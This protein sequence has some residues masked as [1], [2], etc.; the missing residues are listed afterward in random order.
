MARHE[1]RARQAWQREFER[2]LRPFLRVLGHAARRRWAPVSLRGLLAPGERK[3]VQPLAGNVA[4]GD[5]EPLHHVVAT[6]AWP[7]AP[8][9]C[10]LAGEAQRLVGGPGAVLIVDDT[11]LL[12]QGHC[13]VGVARAEHQYSGAA[14]KSA[15][16][17]CLVSLTLAR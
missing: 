14:G 12:K 7:T 16:C 5:Y 10:V 15:N 13:S 9:E 4:P 11:T 3:S 8:L 1:R 17:Q 6:S 2:W